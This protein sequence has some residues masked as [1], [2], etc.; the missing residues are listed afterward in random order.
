[1]E[2]KTPKALLTGITIIYLSI[3]IVPALFSLVVLFLKSKGAIPADPDAD[4]LMFK[5]LLYVVTPAGI[6]ASY[7]IYRNL[8]KGIEPADTL[9]HKMN[10][11]Q[12]FILIR[13]A[14][15]EV[16]ALLGALSAFN[17]GDLSFLAFTGLM[18]VLL[19]FFRP[20]VETLIVD[21][22][23]SDAEQIELTSQEG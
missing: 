3:A 17:T 23:L 9:Q 21:M 15:L 1:M 14:C 19:L 11:V 7:F 5:Y 6:A 18:V 16:P 8:L 22:Q 2:Q 20:T 12:G 13:A 4:P 10:K